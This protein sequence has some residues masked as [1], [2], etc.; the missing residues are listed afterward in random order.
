MK[1][2]FVHEWLET[3]AGSERVLEQFLLIW[4]DA[5]LFAVCDFMPD[6][7]AGLPARQAGHH[8]LH[9]AAAAARGACSANTSG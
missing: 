1:V 2:A 3:Y 9:P 8:Q 6:G 5:D 4:P 7:A